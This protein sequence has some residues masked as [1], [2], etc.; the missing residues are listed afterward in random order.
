MYDALIEGVSPV[1]H[2]RPIV[3]LIQQAPYPE[4][5]KRLRTKPGELR[6]EEGQGKKPS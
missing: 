5:V 1:G 4:P 3:E 6:F 2:D